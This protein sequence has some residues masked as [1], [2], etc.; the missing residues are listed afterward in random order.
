LASELLVNEQEAE[1]E[2]PEEACP[3]PDERLQLIFICCHPAISLE[4]RAALTLRVVCGIPTS[5]IATAFLLSE[6]TLAQ[7]LIR[8]K[9]K[10]AEAGIPFEVPRRADWS[11]RL[12][13]VLSTLEVAYSKAYEDAAATGPQ[14]GY[15]TEIITLT[16]V[17]TEL[18]P[19]ESEVFALA[20]LVRYAEARRPARLD[21]AGMMVPLSEQDPTFWR[22]DLIA[23]ADGYFDKSLGLPESGPR[24]LQAA[25]HR[26]WCKRA[27]LDEPPPWKELLR[28][29]D[30]LL[31]QRGDPIVRLNR[32]IPLAEIYGTDAAIIELE[33][34]AERFPA[35]FA[36]YQ[37]VRA[38][39][40]RRSGRW[41]DA[42]DAYKLAIALDPGAAE[43]LYLRRQLEHVQAK[44][45]YN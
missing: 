8:A 15:A 19:Q 27:S 13:A 32:I 45:R 36:P 43:S 42:Q 29:Y 33:D 1:T 41:R 24:R 23:A 18:M 7:R 31:K 39:L 5:E 11:E 4:S 22:H 44:I 28:I 10:I 16:R 12:S 30:L 25:L 38:D 21:E 14:A 20:A 26:A 37:V 35:N 6:A 17:L 40:M 2:M 3:I 9:R 34:I